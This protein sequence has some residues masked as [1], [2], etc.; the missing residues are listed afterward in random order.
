MADPQAAGKMEQKRQARESK[1]QSKNEMNNKNSEGKDELNQDAEEA[2][3]GHSKKAGGGRKQ[4]QD[5]GEDE[6]DAKMQGEDDAGC[7]ENIIAWLLTKP[8]KPPQP[9]N[10]YRA[11]EIETNIRKRDTFPAGFG[12]KFWYNRI[13]IKK[14]V[15]WGD[16]NGEEERDMRGV[17]VWPEAAGPSQEKE[18]EEEEEEEE[19]EDEGRRRGGAQRCESYYGLF[20]HNQPHGFG[21]F[22]WFEGDMYLGEWKEGALEG[23]GV[24]VYSK[25]G[26][27]PGDREPGST[28]TPE[29]GGGCM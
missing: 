14:T 15:Y 1:R 26:L 20:Q 6:D 29:R 11:E 19:E 3:E 16:R 5:D 25:N 17:C 23:Y 28:A 7:L 18:G 24:Y 13:R 2:L 27:F 22:R 9:W 10:T 12:R 21:I 8:A 4:R